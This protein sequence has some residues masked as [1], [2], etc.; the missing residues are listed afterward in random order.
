MAADFLV[1]LKVNYFNISLYFF[2]CDYLSL[3]LVCFFLY[4]FT[5]T[6]HDF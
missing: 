2:F 5:F 3:V 4:T 1:F 6:F